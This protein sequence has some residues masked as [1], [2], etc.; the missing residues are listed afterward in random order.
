MPANPV[1]NYLSDYADMWTENP[2]SAN[3]KWFAQANYGLFLHYGLYSQLE[4]HEW[5]MFKECIPVAEYE[6]LAQSF[7]PSK[8]D[9]DFI[10]CA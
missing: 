1:P 8:F 10:P 7:Y 4:R 6:K 9:A 3:L 2:R 5:V